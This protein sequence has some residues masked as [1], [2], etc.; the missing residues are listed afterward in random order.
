MTYA[1][2]TLWKFNSFTITVYFYLCL[3]II[4]IPYLY[5]VMFMH[6]F[7][8]TFIYLFIH[9]DK[10]RGEWGNNGFL[11]FKGFQKPQFLPEINKRST[12]YLLINITTLHKKYFNVFYNLGIFWWKS[13]FA[14]FCPTSWVNR[15]NMSLLWENKILKVVCTHIETRI[16]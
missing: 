2:E 5:F 10:N 14:S 4:Y 9:Y 7:V 11:R 1:I 12:T 16:K 6:F 3:V 13:N 15:V 8:M